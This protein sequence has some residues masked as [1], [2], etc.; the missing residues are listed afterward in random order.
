MYRAIIVAPNNVRLNW[1]NEFEKFGTEPGLVNVLRGTQIARA[2]ILIDAFTQDEDSKFTAIIVSYETLC[3]SWDVLGAIPWDIACLDEAHFIKSP[4]TR[5]FKFAR[6]L[7]DNSD[8]RVI[9]TG[10][11]ITNTPL[12]LYAQLEFLAEGRSGF[13]SWKNFKS[14]Y[15]VY[16]SDEG[17][18]TLVGMQNLPFMQERLA[19]SS[20]I[21]TKAE[22][23]PDLPEK[24]Y[25]VV[26]VGM[27]KYQAG[28]YDDVRKHLA[29]EIENS[30]NSDMPKQLLVN[31][32]LTKLLRLAQI[33]SG[34]VVWDAQHNDDGSIAVEKQVERFDPCPKLEALIEM[35]KEKGPNNKTL[36][37]ACW[38][39]DIKAIA[40]RL[41]AE[42]IKAVTFYGGT[43][44]AKREEAEWL[45]N[46]DRDTKVFVGNPAAGG[47][48]L[49]L[50]GYPPGYP[51]GY[52]TNADH[53]IYYSE[54][55]SPTARSQSEGRPHRR[56]TRVPVRITDLCVPGTID[57]EIRTRVLKKIM[58]ALEISDI[59][60]ILDA[61]L[62]GTYNAA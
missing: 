23:L 59:R 39:S 7:R 18:K 45:F 52:D 1:K 62:K 48:G 4:T 17:R 35:L 30:M 55:W 2:K 53:V 58:T 43:S 19:G 11:P 25:D 56:G 3:V 57:E 5:R 61:V 27:S 20:F 12:D 16:R 51:E 37:W 14:F 29:A 49:N 47:V 9:L 32:V 24:T 33:T 50:L 46:Q 22:A 60:H 34:H 8:K 36:V 13:M 10:T 28:I 38:V 54:N 26:E 40:A 15:G 31:N 21:I 6:K 41:E 42:G 44:D